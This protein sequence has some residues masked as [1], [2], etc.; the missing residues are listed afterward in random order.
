MSALGVSFLLGEI[1]L[2]AE[3]CPFL[4]VQT[5]QAGLKKKSQTLPRKGKIAL[6]IFLPLKLI[7]QLLWP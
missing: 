6:K 4:S 3:N 1:G 7:C 2:W 5:E